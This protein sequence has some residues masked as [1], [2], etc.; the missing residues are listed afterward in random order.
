MPLPLQYQPNKNIHLTTEKKYSFYYF[1][2]NKMNFHY[3]DLSKIHNVN[4]AQKFQEMYYDIFKG[5]VFFIND[6]D[7]EDFDAEMFQIY[8]QLGLMNS[9]D[10][11]YDKMYHFYTTYGGLNKYLRE[12]ADENI[13]K[14]FQ[15][16]LLT[17][18]E[19]EKEIKIINKIADLNNGY[20]FEDNIIIDKINYIYQNYDFVYICIAPG[21]HHYIPEFFTEKIINNM[22]TAIIY[23]SKLDLS[24]PPFW[25]NVNTEKT[26][27]TVSESIITNRFSDIEKKL[28]SN[29]DIYIFEYQ[30]A[31][32]SFFL[33]S[34]NKV[35]TKNTLF[36]Y[37]F[38]T[39]G[40]LAKEE[41]DK[42]KFLEN[43][44]IKLYLPM[45]EAD[46][47]DTSDFLQKGG[48][49]LKSKS[50]QKISKRRKNRK[51]QQKKIRN[52]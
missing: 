41:L 29:L 30:I 43:P 7:K 17:V 12:F 49:S 13:L 1:E 25:I 16:Y 18:I 11:T 9:T 51:S 32:D 28:T 27:G 8:I 35:I 46:F 42:F 15:D 45:N 26:N 10:I 38:T 14:K 22:K 33:A 5:D 3:Y 6:E 47:K 23:I 48:I 24:W 39:K 4:N 40:N 20:E 19:D 37:G 2:N 44:Y 21:I 36:Y 50:R 34:L 31:S 52:Y